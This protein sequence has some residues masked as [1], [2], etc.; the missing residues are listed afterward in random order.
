MNGF[1]LGSHNGNFR[2]QPAA[3]KLTCVLLLLSHFAF[4][5]NNIGFVSL[6]RFDKTRPAVEEQQEKERGRIIQINFWYPVQERSGNKI[7]F[8]DYVALAGLELDSSKYS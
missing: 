7:T 4:S 3:M 1:S 2:S 5:Q 8:S 6:T